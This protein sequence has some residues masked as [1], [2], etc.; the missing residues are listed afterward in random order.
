[1]NYNI[2]DKIE[3]N[4][5]LDSYE[6]IIEDI[7][8]GG[9]GVV[10]L[11]KQASS[12]WHTIFRPLIAVKTINNNIF[13]IFNADQFKNELNIWITLDHPN[14]LPLG[15]LVEHKNKLC[16]VMQRCDG[17][18]SDIVHSNKFNDIFALNIIDNIL[19]GLSYALDKYGVLHLDIKPQNILINLSKKKFIQIADWGIANIQSLFYGALLENSNND[20]SKKYSDFGTLIYMSPERLLGSPANIQFDIYSLGIMLYELITKCSIFNTNSSDLIYHKITNYEYFETIKNNNRKI[21]ANILDLIINC[22]N[23][24][25]TKRYSTYNQIKVDLR[26]ALKR[27]NSIFSIFT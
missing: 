25:C 5:K 2:G 13:S 4:N 9:M 10:F 15:A 12:N 21:D 18:I 1:M 7:K 8:H 17:N 22:V 23:P 19:D 26:R 3:L 11:L 6:Y 27:K 20:I 16:A 14:I 24:N